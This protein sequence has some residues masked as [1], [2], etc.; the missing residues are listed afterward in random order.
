[1]L[2]NYL[3][4]LMHEEIIPET[5]EKYSA[6]CKKFRELTWIRKTF[7]TNQKYGNLPKDLCHPGAIEWC[8]AKIPTGHSHLEF[9]QI[10]LSSSHQDPAIAINTAAVFQ[11]MWQRAV[12]KKGTISA[13]ECRGIQAGITLLGR[14][15][16][17]GKS[18]LQQR[19]TQTYQSVTHDF[20]NWWWE[21]FPSLF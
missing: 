6:C 4:T 1:M 16:L 5:P 8:S 20:L 21:E 19:K 18:F 3:L 2:W 7:Q 13:A 17:S 15:W 11:E 10:S 12:R 14:L 9:Q